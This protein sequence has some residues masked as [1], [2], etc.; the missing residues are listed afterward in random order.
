MGDFS[1]RFKCKVSINEVEEDVDW[2]LNYS[3]WQTECQDVDQRV[4]DLFRKLWRRAKA[5]YDLDRAYEE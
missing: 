3:P 5:K 2:Y 1:F 4:I